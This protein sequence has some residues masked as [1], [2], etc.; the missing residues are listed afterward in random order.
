VPIHTVL[1][2]TPDGVVE[3]MLPGG[4]R[5]LTRVPPDPETLSQLATTSGGT[6]FTAY[7]EEGLRMVYEDLGSRL[8][9]REEQREITDVVA[10][11]AAALLLVGGALSAFLFR[12]VP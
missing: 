5:R 7:D 11:A 6:F 3:E 1:L 8:G 10:A 9:E 2:G 4:F 12:R